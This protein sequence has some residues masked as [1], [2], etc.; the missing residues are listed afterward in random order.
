VPSVVSLTDFR[1]EGREVVEEGVGSGVVWDRCRAARPRGPPSLRDNR[2]AWPLDVPRWPAASENVGAALPPRL[3]REP[4]GSSAAAG[5]SASVK[6]RHC[7]RALAGQA[8]LG[9]APRRRGHIIT[10]YHCVARL[11]KDT[12]GQEARRACLLCGRSSA[13]YCYA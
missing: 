6:Q 11:A 1:M 12:T 7:G 3:Q 8:Q 5:S 13:A 10:N 2:L 9:P 4:R